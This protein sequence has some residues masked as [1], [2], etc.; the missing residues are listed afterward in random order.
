MTSSLK[1]FLV[2]R[3]NIDDE[4]IK[5]VRENA[6]VIAEG[7]VRDLVDEFDGMC[8]S[9]AGEL[10]EFARGL[11]AQVLPAIL[12]KHTTGR[13]Y[14][15]E[16]ETKDPVDHARDESNASL[17]YGVNTRLVREA[18]LALRP[19]D[20]SGVD[21]HQLLAEI[22]KTGRI[23]S[24]AQFFYAINSMKKSDEIRSVTTGKYDFKS[25]PSGTPSGAN[26]SA[27]HGNQEHPGS[28]P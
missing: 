18:L 8:A 21:R 1:D 3:Q 16:S 5:T 14:G 6:A 13:P 12:A 24:E 17:V 20:G 19:A 4:L 26:G 10:D 22:Q 9:I 25:P 27:Y 11:A 28:S 23:L 7:R 2:K 15:S